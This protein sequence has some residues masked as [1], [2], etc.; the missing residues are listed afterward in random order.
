M[1]KFLISGLFLFIIM[2]CCAFLIGN[3][4]IE[5]TILSLQVL[6]QTIFFSIVLIFFKF[7]YDLQKIKKVNWVEKLINK[8]ERSIKLVLL[9]MIITIIFDFIILLTFG[10]LISKL[11]VFAVLFI[12]S[13]TLLF[14]VYHFKEEV[15]AF[16]EK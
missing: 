3:T 9:S 15:S 12:N 8:K 6:A 10:K 2:L 7:F 1:K 4:A 5:K 13:A 11:S 16:I 14:F